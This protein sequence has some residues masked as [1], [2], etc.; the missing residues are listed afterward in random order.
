MILGGIATII[1][2]MRKIEEE[3]IGVEITAGEVVGIEEEITAEGV[4]VMEAEIR[5]GTTE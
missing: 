4:V 5:C 3:G 2:E 1:K